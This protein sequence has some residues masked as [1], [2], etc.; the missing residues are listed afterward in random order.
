[1]NAK[2]CATSRIDRTLA[3]LSMAVVFASLGLSCSSFARSRGPSAK[4][5]LNIVS[6]FN[7]YLPPQTKE[8]FDHLS[9]GARDFNAAVKSA[10]IK[11][12][13]ITPLSQ[14]P[15][16]NEDI[17]RAITSVDSPDRLTVAYI[18]SHG[19]PEGFVLKDSLSFEG[20]YQ[21]LEAGTKGRLLL[22]VDSCYSGIITEVL[23]R[24][25]S[26]R[27][28]AITGTKGPTLE[29]WYSKTGS[30]SEALSKTIRARNYAGTDGK[31]SLGELYDAVASDIK[32][33]NARY[34]HS[35]GPIS[36]P[37]MYGPRDLVVLDFNS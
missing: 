35:A 6:V 16:A 28:F 17:I 36:E 15:M 5:N 22:L 14:G 20:L 34:P 7:N 23:A 24:H 4:V 26:R 25:G 29:R 30:F 3:F 27:I 32:G 31:L 37:A 13:L 33:W 21:K 10:Q 11:E 1:M 9:L 8:S 12:V 18:A 19:S 2:Q